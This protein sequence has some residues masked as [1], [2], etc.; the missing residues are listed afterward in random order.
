MKSVKQFLA[1]SDRECGIEV[2]R[3]LSML[4]IVTC[5]VLSGS[6]GG[7]VL[8]L[9]V[10][11]SINW[12]IAWI[13]E[14]I[15]LQAVNCFGLISGYVQCE[16]KWHLRKYAE[17][18]LF[19]FITNLLVY[20][21]TG[22]IGWS[23][24]SN[25]KQILVSSIPWKSNLW[26]VQAY[27]G[28]IILMPVLNLAIEKWSQKKSVLFVIAILSV[29][30]LM[31]ETDVF[32]VENGYST[33]WLCILYLIGGIIKKRINR[34]K[35]DFNPLVL[36]IFSIALTGLVFVSKWLPEWNVYRVAGEYKEIGNLF[37]YSSPLVLL[38]AVCIFLLF[39]KLK[40]TVPKWFILISGASLGIYIIHKHPVINDRFV[41]NCT[42]EMA[43]NN[44]G[45]MILGVA[46]VIASVFLC[47]LIASV[48]ITNPTRVVSRKII[49]VCENTFLTISRRRKL[50]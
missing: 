2:L 31:Y 46:G 24:Y 28:L 43:T 48:V 39:L 42:N 6:G 7:G 23:Q 12:Y 35:V 41:V 9:S 45:R 29:V 10:P 14:S 26:Y 5:H 20:L 25:I 34:G 27:L 22:V 13:W 32:V 49:D 36:F 15:A 1:P 37:V 21:I 40:R 44:I 38:Q 3:L 16:R 19:V 4:M 47:S 18:W 50:K 30:P 11:F 8:R 33:V 17:F